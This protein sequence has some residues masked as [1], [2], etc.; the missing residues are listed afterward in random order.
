MRWSATRS[1][2]SSYRLLAVRKVINIAVCIWPGNRRR[3]S[4]DCSSIRRTDFFPC[5]Q[6]MP[7]GGVRPPRIRLCGESLGEQ[8]HGDSP[9]RPLNPLFK[10]AGRN[11]PTVPNLRGRTVQRPRG[12]GVPRN[13]RSSHLLDTLFG[14][15]KPLPRAESRSYPEAGVLNGRRR[16]RAVP[17][18]KRT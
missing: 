6:T 9:A 16:T 7:S 3:T 8:K 4:I 13:A 17:N 1:L 14:Q 15:F 11:S 10:R 18:G 5:V 12:E 2:F